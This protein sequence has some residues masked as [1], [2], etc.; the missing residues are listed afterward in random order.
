MVLRF[1][2]GTENLRDTRYTLKKTAKC[3][4][5]REGFTYRTDHLRIDEIDCLNPNLP[6]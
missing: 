3:V 5:V 4:R 1:W 6:L 2:S